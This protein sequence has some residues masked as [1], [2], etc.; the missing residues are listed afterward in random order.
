MTFD[1][2]DLSQPNL[3][4]MSEYRNSSQA[5]E[6]VR[7]N[8]VKGEK[9]NEPP[10]LH[11]PFVAIFPPRTFDGAMSPAKI[12]IDLD[13]SLAGS[14]NVH[15]YRSNMES[16]FAFTQLETSIVDGRAVANTNQGGVFVAGSQ[17]NYGLVIGL[18]VTGVVLL[19]F[20]I[21]VVGVIVYFVARPEKWQSAKTNVKKSQMKIKRSFARQV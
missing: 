19:L 21:I 5:V 13:S 3:I 15:I 17:V 7:G 1:R 9:L 11:S 12:S 18:V 20:A 6:D 14:S 16:A 2:A 4:I 10:I 8:T